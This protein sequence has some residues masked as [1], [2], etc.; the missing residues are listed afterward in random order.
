MNTAFQVKL[1]KDHRTLARQ[2]LTTLRPDDS[3]RPLYEKRIAELDEKI[4]ALGADRD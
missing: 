2:K 3:K 4:A 1:L